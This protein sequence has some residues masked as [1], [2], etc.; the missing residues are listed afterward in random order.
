MTL[1]DETGVVNVVVWPWV[2]EIFRKAVL[3]GRLVMVRGLIQRAGEIVHQVAARL[4]N[5]TQ[6]FRPYGTQ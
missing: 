4:E 6:W 5:L 3:G 2:L 1:E